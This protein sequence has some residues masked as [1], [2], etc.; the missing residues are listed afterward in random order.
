[1]VVPHLFMMIL[2]FM[3]NQKKK[4][5][6]S[7]IIFSSLVLI[8]LLVLLNNQYGLERFVSE[9]PGRFVQNFSGLTLSLV[10]GEIVPEGNIYYNHSNKTKK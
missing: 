10:R 1:M 3:S 9:F 4:K 5:M 6:L 7:S 2:F 8:M